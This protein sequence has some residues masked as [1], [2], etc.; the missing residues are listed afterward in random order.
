MRTSTTRA[1]GESGRFIVRVEADIDFLIREL[2]RA[3][4]AR[5]GAID[6]PAVRHPNAPASSV[7]RGDGSMP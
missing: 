4:R 1:S 7:A 5:R 3:V 2:S 6:G